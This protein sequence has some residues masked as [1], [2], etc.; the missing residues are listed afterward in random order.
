MILHASAV[1]DLEVAQGLRRLVRMKEITQTRASAAFVDLC[2]FAM[3]RHSHAL[4][5]PRIWTLR[6]NISAYDAA[7]VA[8][9]EALDCPLL[10]RDAKL[11]RFA[12]RHVPVEVLKWPP[13]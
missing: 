8:L 13:S 7:Y 3:V 5:M 6:G 10:T 9:A 12:R 11:A 4:L 1:L 2:D